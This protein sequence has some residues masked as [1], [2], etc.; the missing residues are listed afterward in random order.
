VVILQRSKAMSDKK[1]KRLCL[2]CLH[3]MWCCQCKEYEN[4][5]QCQHC[6]HYDDVKAELHFAAISRDQNMK[7]A[8]QLQAD[9][10]MCREALEDYAGLEIWSEPSINTSGVEHLPDLAK[11]TLEKLK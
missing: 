10:A 5:P 3:P 8:K 9:L 7:F 4:K 11:Q 1:D 2:I 6:S